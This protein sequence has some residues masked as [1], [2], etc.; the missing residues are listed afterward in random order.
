M[1]ADKHCVIEE[2]YGPFLAWRRRIGYPELSPEWCKDQVPFW[3]QKRYTS[4]VTGMGD[5]V[6]MVR[7]GLV[8]L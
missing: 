6:P 5:R 7:V 1:A 8:S 2:F 4:E 3:P